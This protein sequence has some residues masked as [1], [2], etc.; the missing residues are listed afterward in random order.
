MRKSKILVIALII[1]AALATEAYFV[2]R[3][4]S[5]EPLKIM[6]KDQPPV[7]AKLVYMEPTV[8]EIQLQRENDGKWIT[9]WTG[10]QV[11]HVEPGAPENLFAQVIVPAD[12]YVGSRMSWSSFIRAVD[13]NLDNDIVDIHPQYQEETKELL[14]LLPDSLN[15]LNPSKLSFRDFLARR[16]R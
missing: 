7:S 13:F 4:P 1:I 6:F 14:S 12:N 5:L 10:S 9:I 2:T 3:P 8:T 16:A 11:V 15:W